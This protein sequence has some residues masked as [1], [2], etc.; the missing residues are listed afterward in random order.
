MN[1]YVKNKT[2]TWTHAMKRAVGPGE[3][4]S[5]SSLYEQYG[6]KHDLA[7]GEEF[8]NWLR[9]IKLRD[10]EVWEIVFEGE[11]G[12]LK[13]KQGDEDKIVEKEEEEILEQGPEMGDDE[14]QATVKEMTVNDVSGLSVRNGRE[15]LPNIMDLNLLKY[16]LQQASQLSGKDTL[17]NMLRKRIQELQ[18]S[19]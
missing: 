12:Q 14:L 15:I 11:D 9:K 13:E 4:I 5:L 2:F 1:G 19:R 10:K 3:K 18:I 8:I 16:S 7:E 6:E 17:C